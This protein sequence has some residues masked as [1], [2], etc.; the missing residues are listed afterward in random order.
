M[1]IGDLLIVAILCELC[2][3][4]ACSVF[5]KQCVVCEL[6]PLC[7]GLTTHDVV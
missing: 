3:C 2:G 6:F 7:A 5:V 4:Y 1:L